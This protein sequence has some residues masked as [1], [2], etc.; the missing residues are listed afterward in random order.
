[1]W[2]KEELIKHYKANIIVSVSKIA[3]ETDFNNYRGISLYFI[4]KC[5]QIS[6]G[7]GTEKLLAII[8]VDSNIIYHLL[9]RYSTF[10]TQWRKHRNAMGQYINYL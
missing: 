2:N 9:T 4:Q 1:M 10:L 7:K 3:N 8:N 5:Y 6:S